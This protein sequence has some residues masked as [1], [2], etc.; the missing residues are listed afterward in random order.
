MSNWS[1]FLVSVR[2]PIGRTVSAFNWRKI[3]GGYA[4]L[5][6]RNPEELAFEGKL[7]ASRSPAPPSRP[8]P[9]P[10]PNIHP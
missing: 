9:H 1:K 3:D 8:A 5:P 6:P 2:D 4:D 7:C 10:T